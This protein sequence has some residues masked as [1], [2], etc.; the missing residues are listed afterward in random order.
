MRI[1]TSKRS[2]PVSPRKN[3]KTKEILTTNSAN[4]REALSKKHSELATAL[5]C[6]E[7]QCLL[8]CDPG[9]SRMRLLEGTIFDRPP[10]CD[11][12]GLPETE[13]KCPPV[14]VVPPFVPP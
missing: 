10:H 6:T 8:N 13:C 12:C 1:R 2:W 7:K 9:I 5:E 3:R 14:K 11:R 4:R